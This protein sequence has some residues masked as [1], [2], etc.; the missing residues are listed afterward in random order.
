MQ[1]IKE[2]LRMNKDRMKRIRS[3]EEAYIRCFS[4]YYENDRIIRYR[5]PELPDMYDHNFTRIKDPLSDDD[6]W[7]LIQQEI[8]FNRSENKNFCKIVLDKLPAEMHAFAIYGSPTIEHNGYYYY[9][10]M[11]SPAWKTAEECGIRKTT[12]LSMAQQ[13]LALDL[14]HDRQSCGEDFCIRRVQRRTKVYLSDQP[15]DSYLCD[16]AGKPVGNCDLFFSEGTAKIEDFAVLPDYQRRRIG[17]FILKHM[18]DT[19]LSEGA[20]LIYLV[21]DEDDTPKEMYSKL[22]F[23]KVA[24]SYALFWKYTA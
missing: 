23:E 6:L 15:C 1:I 20:R 24:D 18:V 2:V 4:S 21:A 19:A 10:P 8:D 12:D 14:A 16:Y 22:G 5:D 13:L 3:C 7:K 9:A 17:T 11:R